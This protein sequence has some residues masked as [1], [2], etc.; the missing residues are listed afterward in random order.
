MTDWFKPRH[1]RHLDHPVGPKFAKK[2]ERPT[3]V[4]SHDFLPLLKRVKRERR[5]KLHSSGERRSEWKDRPIMYASHRDACVLSFYSV[6]LARRLE[7][8]YADQNL[9]DCALA[10]RKTGLG[11]YDFAAEAFSYVKE[12]APVTILAFDVTGFFDNLDHK[13]LKR[14]LCRLLGAAKLSDDWHR[15]F[16]A[17]TRYSCIDLD[18]LKAHPNLADQF[19]P[20]VR[21]PIAPIAELK[22]SGVPI[23]H[24]TGSGKGIPQGTP[25]SATLSNAYMI[26]FDMAAKAF[27]EQH[28]ALYRRYSDDILV[29]C[30]PQ[31]ASAIEAGIMRFIDREK[32][33]I[34]SGKT[35]R[36]TFDF[37]SPRSNSEALAQYLGFVWTRDGAMIRPQSLARR[38][39]KLKRHL[40]RMERIVTEQV[41]AGLPVEIWTKAFRRRFTRPDFQ[42]FSSYA[43][44]S[45]K[46]FGEAPHILRQVRRLERAA[47]QGLRKLK[48]RTRS[49]P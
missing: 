2:V 10:Y 3:F 27:C 36:T 5:Y 12:N 38:R 45:A 18:G 40:R 29:V 8:F 24:H 39:R 6:M 33:Q 46:A 28:G 31:D 14:R 9:G 47:E 37:T 20:G 4:A 22:Q 25:I 32:L 26:D 7:A 42:N 15:V 30:K 19:R 43:R 41:A 16:R 44:R 1:Y 23:Y 48:D 11:N 35:E 49:Q 21:G 34:N 13:L 17:M